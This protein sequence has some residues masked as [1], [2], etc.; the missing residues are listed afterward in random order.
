MDKEREANE[1]RDAKIREDRARIF[2]EDKVRVACMVDAGVPKYMAQAIYSWYGDVNV[3]G[4]GA[5]MD[6]VTQLVRLISRAANDMRERG[7]LG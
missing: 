7:E 1:K 2:P 5:T 3:W 6:D 4:S